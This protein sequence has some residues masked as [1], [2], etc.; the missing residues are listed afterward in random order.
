MTI[1]PFPSTPS[2]PS[3]EH[4]HAAQTKARLR[5]LIA[6]ALIVFWG[7]TALTGFLLY[8][9]PSGPRSGQLVLL[10]FSKAQWGDIHFWSSIAAS[11]VT[12]LHMAIDWKA[13]KSCARFLVSTERGQHP[14]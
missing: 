10:L 14:S 3:T 2:Q 9:S 4:H 12:I 13:L 11:A 1:K 7:I 6:L 5:A 8:I